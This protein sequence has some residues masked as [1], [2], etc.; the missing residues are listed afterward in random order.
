[1]SL[2]YFIIGAIAETAVLLSAPQ[3][4]ES[5][6]DHLC[7][8]SSFPPSTLN[9]YLDI[10][11]YRSTDTAVRSRHLVVRTGLLERCDGAAL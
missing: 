5:V 8:P 2:Y 9:A 6:L 3:L 1:M 7:E 10:C 4:L 11:I